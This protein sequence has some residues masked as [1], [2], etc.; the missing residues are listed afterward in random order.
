MLNKIAENSASENPGDEMHRRRQRQQLDAMLGYCEIV[1]CRR[2]M[3]LAYFG[4]HMP[5]PCGNCDTCLTPPETYDGTVAAQKILSCVART[6]QRF[7]AQHIID[8]LRGSEN[9][10]IRRFGHDQLPTHG[11]GQEFDAFE[12]RSVIRQLVAQ[13]VLALDPEGFGG[14]RWTGE[15]RAVVRGEREMRLRRDVLTK[16]ARR[17]KAASVALTAD[18]DGEIDAA[19]AALYERLR[20]VRRL[21]AADQGVPPYVIFHDKTLAAMAVHKPTNEEAFLRL[22][23][24]GE[25]KMERYGEEFMRV[26]REEDTA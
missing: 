1:D 16:T 5:E 25:K 4:E 21:L 6:G 14:L 8:V 9:E 15:S 10:R 11:V 2:Q 13:G 20:E 26:V 7:G 3:L 19:T 12:W 22:S 18:M 17:K 23:G 24:V